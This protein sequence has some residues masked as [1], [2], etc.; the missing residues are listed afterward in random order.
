MSHLNYSRN[1][2]YT[3]W[4]K[5]VALKKVSRAIVTNFIRDNVIHFGILKHLLHH[6]GTPSV[7][8]FVKIA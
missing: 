6:N 7:N 5:A 4:V 8:T 1:E 2:S 3:K